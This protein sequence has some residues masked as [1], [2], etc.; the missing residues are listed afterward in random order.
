MGR[1]YST[2]RQVLFCVGRPTEFTDF[3]FDSIEE[4]LTRRPRRTD[5]QTGSISVP[6]ELVDPVMWHDFVDTLGEEHYMTKHRLH[7]ACDALLGGSWFQRVRIVQE[8]ANSRQG[9][10][11][12][13]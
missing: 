4:F 9:T 7:M 11:Y 10:V 12:C 6:D 2:A 5:D 3:L 1:V 8:V 13:G